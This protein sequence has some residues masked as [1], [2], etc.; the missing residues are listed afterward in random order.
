MVQRWRR[1]SRRMADAG[2]SSATKSV[3]IFTGGAVI[4]GALAFGAAY[5]LA[6]YYGQQQ[7][8]QDERSK[9]RPK[10]KGCVRMA[11]AGPMAYPTRS[12]L[13]PRTPAAD[14]SLRLCRVP[15]DDDVLQGSPPIAALSQL[16]I[17]IPAGP[18][19]G[20]AA[21][22]PVDRTGATPRPFTRRQTLRG[23][24][25]CIHLCAGQRG[26]R[27]QWQG[28]RTL[29]RRPRGDACFEPH[30]DQGRAAAAGHDVAAGHAGEH[31]RG[32]NGPRPRG[33]LRKQSK[34]PGLVTAGQAPLGPC[35]APAA[36]AAG[37]P[38][39][40]SASPLEAVHRSRIS[41][42]LSYLSQVWPGVW[43]VQGCCGH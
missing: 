35:H 23:T 1:R 42:M 12:C 43:G 39:A 31:S 25:P 7:R 32:W 29:R 33:R 37:L 24:S 8:Q 41:P 38:V 10:D 18:A 30:P 40:Q 5:G 34:Q 4:G 15:A 2:S 16:Q 22:L 13:R 6:T 3:L 36:P 17:G 21:V 26:P 28:P 9:S 27:S 14:V 19:A 11:P 20:A